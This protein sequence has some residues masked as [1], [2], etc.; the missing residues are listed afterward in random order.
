[1][2]MLTRRTAIAIG[3]AACAL[4]SCARSAPAAS[5]LKSD[6]GG[7]RRV[8]VHSI[9]ATDFPVDALGDDLLPSAESDM[10][11]A[12]R[13]QAGMI[14][15]LRQ[16]GVE[17]VELAEALDGAI[18]ATRASGVF[19]AWLD[20]VNPR[21][22][23]NP[24]RVKAST[25]LG[26]DAATRYQ[27]GADKTYRHIVDDSTSTMW[28]RDSAFMTPQGLVMCNSASQRRGRE[29]TLLRFAYAHSPLLKKYPVIF[30]AVEEGLII[31]GG[32]A[33]VVD[34]RTLYLGVGNR[35]DPRIA[36]VLAQRLNM[37]VLTVQTFKTDFLRRRIPGSEIEAM[38]LRL[39]FLHL[40]TYFTHVAPKHALVMPLVL[41][42][43][44]EEQNPLVRYVR[45][46]RAATLI[47][48]DEAKAALDM[49]KELGDVRLF[50]RGT[51]KEEDMGDFKLVDYV[52]QNGYRLTYTGG[53]PP[54]GDAE[55]FRHFMDVTY[56]EHRRQ[57]TNVVQVKP[58]R[59][60]QY[61]GVPA[62]KAALQK[63]GITVDSFEARDL[64]P[65]HG[66]PHC[67]TQPLERY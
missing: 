26:R 33:Q 11:A 20:A 43:A 10:E 17:V 7:L 21:L 49:L 41:E 32:V 27:L 45:G 24:A 57:A 19:E 3:A 48:D 47:P 38:D 1:M 12:V 28:T 40:D 31:E 25:L 67:L 60:L 63:D 44:R 16:Q 9:K 15:L 22:G 29:N 36:P 46:A 61:A 58:G 64:W 35:T 66:G 37:D 18:E 52:K 4:P 8:L 65:W 2:T 34:E 51:G 50:R 42:K 30:D 53:L 56:R 62:T 14:A 23:A 13:N 5:F 55:Q 59:V 39:L 54:S 6:I